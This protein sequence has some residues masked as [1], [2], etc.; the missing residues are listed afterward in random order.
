MSVTRTPLTPHVG[1][2]ITGASG[3]RA[4]RPAWSPTTASTA[5][6]AYGVVVYRDVH[7]DDDDLVAFSRMLGEVAVVP[8]R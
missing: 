7:I 3:A 8:D 4:R 6:T 5:S 2:E 1:L